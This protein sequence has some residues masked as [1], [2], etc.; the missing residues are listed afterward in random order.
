VL[1]V[2]AN[3]FAGSAT[4]ALGLDGQPGYG[5][6]TAGLRETTL[7]AAIEYARV[8]QFPTLAVIP[9]GATPVA[10]RFDED[11]V[12]RILLR[13]RAEADIIIISGA[14]VHQS[15]AAL[16][17]GRAADGTL[18]VVEAGGT[19]LDRVQESIR[20]LNAAAAAVIGTVLGRRRRLRGMPALRRRTTPPAPEPEAKPEPEPEAEPDPTPEAAVEKEKAGKS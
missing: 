5:E 12:E 11:F 19:D 7:F 15:P 2:D 18:L 17:W 16:F 14:P 6:L 10:D 3:E 8:D 9:R 20:S 4:A 13:F 1:L